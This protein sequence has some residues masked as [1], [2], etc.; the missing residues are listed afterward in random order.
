MSAISGIYHFNKQPV[1]QADLISLHSAMQHHG[2]DGEGL[3]V[4]PQCGLA[5]QTSHLTQESLLEKFPIIDSQHHITL[6]AHCRLFNYKELSNQLTPNQSAGDGELIILAYLKWKLDF[7]AHLVGEFS[8]A[9]WD[10][11]NQQLVCANDHFNSQPLYY[12]TDSHIVAFAS[13]L[14]A[15]HRLKTIPRLPN[16]N[17]IARSDFMRFQLEPGETCFANIHYLPP[18]SVMIINQTDL[19]IKNYWK[20]TLGKS[21]SFKSDQAFTDEFQHTF[22]TA[23]QSVTRTHLP[24][25]LQLSGGLDSSAI[26]MTAAKVLQL[27]N[28]NLTCLSN[29][30][31]PLY[32]G[33]TQDERDFIELVQAPNLIKHPV[34]DE[35]RGPF[36]NLENFA[37]TLQSNPQHY[38][39]RA[40]NA[41]A[42]AHNAKFILHGTLGELTSSYNG[43]EYLA[44][45]FYR[46]RWLSLT[47]EM[48]A[49]QKIYGRSLKSMMAHNLIKPI[50]PVSWQARLH[51]KNHHELIKHSLINPR[52]I[53]QQLN[54]THLQQLKQQFVEQSSLISTDSRKNALD[55]VTLFLRH[56]SDLFNHLSDAPETA[57]YF[58]NPYFDK[59]FVEF[60]LNVPSE[61][62]FKNGYARSMIRLGMKDVLPEKIRWRICKEPFLPDYHDRYNKQLPQARAIVD[63]LSTH[64]LVQDII[65][66]KQLK[67]CLAHPSTSNRLDTQANFMNFLV[68]P[69]MI[70]LAKFLSS[71]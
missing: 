25:C 55:D 1:S 49:H 16:L 38:Q 12:Y 63:E 62:R 64:P 21:L 20:P 46:G 53:Q 59:R 56:S 35:W 11:K 15:L 30:L 10:N 22:T 28:K 45:L 17:K 27:Q 9:L 69:R 66:I 7:A 18:A 65:N 60:C 8:I 37:E 13:E 54:A 71:F 58:S 31:P 42:R 29:V 32:R 41:A 61:Y 44:H 57:I 68:I 51:S 14:R 47:R 24:I 40:I 5:Q 36:D 70:Y 23:I 50:L 2:Q 3:Y 67:Q 4:A 33:I 26:A 39:Y 6:V 52:F 34:I 48:L 19:T 43:H